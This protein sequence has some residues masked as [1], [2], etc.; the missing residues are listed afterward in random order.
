M[1][2]D[3]DDKYKTRRV[4]LPGLLRVFGYVT[5]TGEPRVSIPRVAS[6]I[7]LVLILIVVYFTS[8]SKTATAN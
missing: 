6:A 4:E 1:T 5:E 2:D 3:D 8:S 7:I